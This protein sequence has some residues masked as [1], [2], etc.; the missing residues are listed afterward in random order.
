[1]LARGSGAGS[2]QYFRSRR[3]E[4]TCAVRPPFRERMLDSEFSLSLKIWERL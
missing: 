3:Q 4:L 1:M 2:Y